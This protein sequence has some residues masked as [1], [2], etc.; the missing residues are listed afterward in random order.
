[1]RIGSG[2]E[3]SRSG[4]GAEVGAEEEEEDEW[5]TV[6]SLVVRCVLFG[7]AGYRDTYG[8]FG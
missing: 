6:A 1:M 5:D 7:R 2:E 8:V 3:T 4:K